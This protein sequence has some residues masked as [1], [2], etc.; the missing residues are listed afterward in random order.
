M[1]RIEN[2]YLNIGNDKL[3]IGEKISI[4]QHS[5]QVAEYANK[6]GESLEVQ[7]AC[8]L[9]DIGHLL[10]LEANIE[11]GMEG[12]GIENHE[13]IGA[14]F[15]KNIGLSNTIC[16][17]VANHVNAKRYLCSKHKDYYNNLSNASKT[18]LKYQGGLM[19]NDE[20]INFENNPLFLTF[21]RCRKYDEMGK[22]NINLLDPYERKY[23]NLLGD[24]RL[25]QEYILS[26]YQKQIYQNNGYIIIKNG[27]K[28]IDIDD[29]TIHTITKNLEDLPNDINFPW[30][31][32]YER[33]DNKAQLCRIENFSKYHK[34]WSKIVEYINNIVSQ[35]Y[36]E[37]TVL[38]KEKINFKLPGGGG[39]LPHQDVT[40][41]ASNEFAKEHISAMVVIDN[42][43]HKDQGPL[44][45]SRGNHKQGI[46]ENRDGVIDENVLLGYNP[47]FVNSGDLVFFGSYL[48]HKSGKNISDIKR[49]IAY[50]TF[51]KLSE[52]EFNSVYYRKKIQLGNNISINKDFAGTIIN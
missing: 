30:F 38:F 48:P 32:Y 9:H 52:G 51:N 2:L 21:I 50:F 15:L 42:C 19:N 20:L 8:F 7:L 23:Y 22:D 17:I 31:K 25:K 24:Y 11:L 41:Y 46:Y 18:T 12:C 16:E 5:L 37:K 49:R 26:E 43:L 33:I 10:G 3:Y 39:F 28:Y 4:T 45:V 47:L 27:L 13:Q 44:Q 1:N 6:S 29:T 14:D 36:N 40:A 35:L 34:T